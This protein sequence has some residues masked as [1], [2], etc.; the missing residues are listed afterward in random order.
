MKVTRLTPGDLC[1]CLRLVASGGVA[2]DGQESAEAIVAGSHS[3][4]GPNTRSLLD[5]E[6]SM[7]DGDADKRAGKPER[8][9]R[10]GGGTAEGR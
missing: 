7:R 4:G 8:S 10:A 2:K 5:T 1:V 6:R 3:G 9:P